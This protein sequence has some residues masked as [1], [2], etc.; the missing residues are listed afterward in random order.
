MRDNYNTSALAGELPVSCD[1]VSDRVSS[2][3]IM[4]GDLY[5]MARDV[6]AYLG[7]MKDSAGDD[8]EFAQRWS[9]IEEQ[10]TKR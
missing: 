3:V 2:S 9:E 1:C 10:Y 8:L 6:K 4:S 5:G 7:R